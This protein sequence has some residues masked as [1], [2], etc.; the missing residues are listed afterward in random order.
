V[1]NQR[2]VVDPV[3]MSLDL[4]LEGCRWF[5]LRGL[6]CRLERVLEIKVQV[7]GADYAIPTS[8]VAGSQSVSGTRKLRGRDRNAYRMFCSVSTAR[9]LTPSLWPPAELARGK[10]APVS[11]QAASVTK[12]TR[13]QGSS[14]HSLSA[15]GPFL[16]SLTS[17]GVVV[18]DGGDRIRLKDSGPG[19][20]V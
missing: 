7:P 15:G 12:A 4:L 14:Y 13:A 20:R 16:P 17:L 3:G 11:K 10:T 18:R 8:G 2:D 5:G 19:S 6:S 1:L 9:P